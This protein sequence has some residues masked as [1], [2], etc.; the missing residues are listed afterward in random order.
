M[1]DSPKPSIG[2]TH[3]LVTKQQ[4]RAILTLCGTQTESG[5]A[6]TVVIPPPAAPT[7]TSSPQG[8]TNQGIRPTFKWADPGTDDAA[9]SYELTVLDGGATV[10]AQTPVVATSFTPAHDL[11]YKRKLTLRVRVLNA[12]GTSGWAQVVFTTQD[13]PPVAP[14]LSSYD[15]TGRVLTGHGVLPSHTVSVR[16]RGQSALTQPAHH[17]RTR[18]PAHRRRPRIR[19]QPDGVGTLRHAC[20]GGVCPEPPGTPARHRS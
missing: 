3:K 19:D 13:V 8:A 4:V 9:A 16:N 18:P 14:V 6:V 7:I 1:A 20:G 15:F 12:S 5:P 10:I 17:Q 11:N 2:L